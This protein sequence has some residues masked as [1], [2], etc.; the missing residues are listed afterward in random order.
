MVTGRCAFGQC[1]SK[2]ATIMRA[3]RLCGIVTI[4][5]VGACSLDHASTSSAGASEEAPGSVR[6]TSGPC[7]IYVATDGDDAN[8]G[9]EGAP[10][11]SLERARDAV[12]AH[13]ASAR[14]P[15]NVCLRGGTYELARA[16][17]LAPANSGTAAA[18]ITYRSYPG[19]RATLSGGERIRPRWRPYAGDVYVAEVTGTFNQLFVDGQRAVRA[20]SPNGD[21][22]YHLSA[23]SNSAARAMSFVYEPGSLPAGLGESDIEIVSMERWQAPRQRIASTTA[24]TVTTEGSLYADLPYGSDYAGNDRY[25]VENTLSALDSP[26][27]WY[28]D[29]K[30]HR[31]YY[32]PRDPREIREGDFVVP[33]LH[34]LV[35]G[36]T[37]PENTGYMSL[38]G[39]IIPFCRHVGVYPRA[40]DALSFGQESFT[41]ASWLRLPA[42][43]TDASWVFTKGEPLGPNAAG[44]PG[45]GY[46]LSAS[47]T[48]AAV[49]VQFFVGDGTHTVAASA[50][51]QPR[52]TWV[53]VAFVVDRFARSMRAYVNGLLVDTE[54]ISALGAIDSNLPL[55]VGEYTNAGCSSSAV[56]DLRVYRAALSSAQVAQVAAGAASSDDLA[57][58]LPFDGDYDDHATPPSETIAFFAPAFMTGPSGGRA[59]DFS[60]YYPP[61]TSESVDYIGFSDLGFEFVDWVMPFTGYPGNTQWWTSPAAVYLHA[62]EATVRRNDFRHL[63]SHAVSGLF[64]DSTIDD[65]DISDVGGGGIQVGQA[66]PT[67]NGQNILAQFASNDTIT[68]NR[69]RDVGIV[70]RDAFAL[71]ITQGANNVVSRNIIENVP[72]YGIT[73]GFGVA[74]TSKIATGNNHV[75]LNR[76]DHVMQLLN[77]G[78]GI[79]VSGE[80]PGTVIERNVVHDVL[81]TPAHLT[82]GSLFGIYLDGGSNSF[83]V[84]N[85][86]TY[87]IQ[88]SSLMLN[89]AVYGNGNNVVQ[90]NIFVDGIDCQLFFNNASFDSFHQNIVYY[91]RNPASVL[92]CPPNAGVP[93]PIGSSNDNLFYSPDAPGFA[94]Q[95]AAWQALCRVVGPGNCTPLEYDTNSIAVDP[96]FVDYAGDDY[97]LEPSSPALKPVGSGGIGFQPIDFT[98]LP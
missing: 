88:Y 59:A 23:V 75:F 22:S 4:L 71:W 27:E 92:F 1:F 80:Q 11:A 81:V 50:G 66:D 24:T 64:A 14:A 7:Q 12:R 37:Y 5:G 83:T 55:D 45:T 29:A 77:D 38:G 79:Y 51:V 40:S 39:G 13:E 46:G 15:V 68:S 6:S 43:A 9:T 32:W 17:T 63:G 52:A 96:Q 74:G 49:P 16:F 69:I 70:D 31:L 2:G 28:L 85:N 91:A 19:E 30:Q 36:G 60:T 98:G 33:R 84:Q 93:P 72:G 53:H 48:A 8:P 67:K 25:Y 57:L 97:S 41:V 34:Q 95:L 58:W 89:A 61:D 73:E 21:A 47:S 90:N 42:N 86:L 56:G 26:G 76:I 3:V 35:R 94:V 87:R 10:F 78:A 20:R 18:P 44:T 65:N 62:R 82:D 54:D